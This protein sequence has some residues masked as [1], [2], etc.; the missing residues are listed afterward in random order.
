MSDL[1]RLL[2]VISSVAGILLGAPAAAYQ[3]MSADRFVD[4]IAVNTHINY[5]DGAYANVKNVR[6]DLAWLGVHHVRDAAPGASAPMSSY[7]Y[8][9]VSDI[10]FDFLVRSEIAHSLAQIKA[11]ETASRGSVDAVE[12]FNEINNWPV[13]YDGLKGDAAG[14]AAQRAIYAFVRG[15]PSLAGIP[16]YDLTGYNVSSV[17]TRFGSAD[18]ANQHV[19]PQNG[20]QPGYNANGDAWIKMGIRGV[21]RFDLPLVITEFGYFSLPQSG[22]YQIGVDEESQAKGILNGLFDAAV[23]GVSRMYLYEL[24]DEKADPRGADA[25][26]HY[27]LF[28]FENRAKPAAFALHNLTSMLKANGGTAL[29]RLE[30]EAWRYTLTDLPPS[31]RSLL[32]RKSDGAFELVLWNEVPFW[33]HT[34]GKPLNSPSATVFVDLGSMAARVNLYDPMRGT[35]PLQTQRNV[36]QV[37][38]DVPDHPV[39]LDIVFPN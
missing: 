38:V 25:G 19:Y 14:L 10:K 13:T 18:Y 28:T 12:G 1:A 22:W 39:L 23:S 35:A 8:L 26:M 20:E 16:V 7:A 3:A 21:E 33:D 5:T 31:G 36:Q 15:D 6:D 11:V 29:N 34:S 32:L 9:A 17:T 4:G 37:R 2:C 24:L 30:G 27:G